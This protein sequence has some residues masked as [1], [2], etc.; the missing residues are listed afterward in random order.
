[1]NSRG[2]QGKVECTIEMFNLYVKTDCYDIS[3][4][5]RKFYYEGH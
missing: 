3:T 2:K 5:W 4:K 1:M